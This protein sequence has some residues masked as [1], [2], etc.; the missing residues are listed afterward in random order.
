MAPRKGA[1]A[2]RPEKPLPGIPEEQEASSRLA[3][4]RSPSLPQLSGPKIPKKTLDMG[5]VANMD[6]NTLGLETFRM[7]IE[8]GR[9]QRNPAFVRM[10][11]ENTE[12][13][14]N[15]VFPKGKRQL[16]N[17]LEVFLACEKRVIVP[18]YEVEMQIANNLFAH[19]P[20]LG[21]VYQ[22]W[23]LRYLP[24]VPFGRFGSGVGSLQA[25][26]SSHPVS[27]LVKS[28]HRMPNPFASMPNLLA[29]TRPVVQPLRAS[30]PSTAAGKRGAV[31][32]AQTPLRR[33]SGEVQ[34]SSDP[35]GVVSGLASVYE[36]DP[37]RAVFCTGETVLETRED[38]GTP[39]TP[40]TTSRPYRSLSLRRES[41][42]ASATPSGAI[43][44]GVARPLQSSKGGRSAASR[45]KES[46]LREQAEERRAAMVVTRGAGDAAPVVEKGGLSRWLRKTFAPSSTI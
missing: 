30:A 24:N 37:D 33:V 35:S 22:E 25:A 44:P 15:E 45:Q 34:A 4:Y 19:Y 26:L 14:E 31:M 40:P 7:N 13:M 6:P 32:L 27:G 12:L 18:E 43:L 3:P 11:Q 41:P 42:T 21:K 39:S 16:K 5:R 17:P 8:Y 38:D 2:P 23:S 28:L 29:T 46:G 10:V 1:A 9:R 36:Y 20:I